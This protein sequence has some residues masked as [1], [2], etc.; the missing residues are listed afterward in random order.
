MVLP[1]PVTVVALTINLG[2]CCTTSERHVQKTVFV[3][4]LVPAYNDQIAS[5]L[6][7]IQSK[8]DAE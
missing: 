7:I 2:L 8:D 3:S 5:L 4:A 1:A 6:S